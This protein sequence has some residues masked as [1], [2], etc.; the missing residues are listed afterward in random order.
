MSTRLAERQSTLTAF[1]TIEELEDIAETVDHDLAKRLN[2]VIAQLIDGLS[3]V[4]ISIA[5]SLLELSKPTVESWTQRGLLV[6]ATED[7]RIVKLDAHRLYEVRHL[8]K[9]LREQGA[10]SGTLMEK[11]WYRLQD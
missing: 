11:V 3:P 1:N 4:P 7:S 2:K 10:K 5:V 6:E 8:V 9:M